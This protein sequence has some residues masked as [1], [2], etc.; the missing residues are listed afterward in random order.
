ML[1][2][3]FRRARRLVKAAAC[4]SIL[5]QNQLRYLT[6]VNE[7][8]VAMLLPLVAL[9]ANAASTQAQAQPQAKTIVVVGQRIDDA[10]DN[11]KACIARHCNPDEEI[12]A[13]LAL[14]ENQLLAGKY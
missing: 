11:L 5:R 13:T 12:D 8:G 7:K 14:A 1:R 4:A 9:L 6:R 3:R 10:A 2:R